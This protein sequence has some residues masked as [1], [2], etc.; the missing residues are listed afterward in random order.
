MTARG[1][2]RT[3]ARP[4]HGTKD[5]NATVWNGEQ[6]DLDAY[7]A[8]LGHEG[9]RSPTLE[10]LRAVHRAHVLTVRWDALDSFLYRA[11]A[12]DLP[13]LQ[14][15]LLRRGRGGYC[16]EHALLYGAALERLGFRFTGVAA[17]IRMGSDRIIAATHAMKVVELDGARWLSDIGFGAGPLGPIEL[18]DGNEVTIEGWPFLLR[19]GEFTPGTDGWALHHRDT[20]G[21]WVVRHTFTLTPQYPVDYE[22]GSHYV[23]SGP[24]SA[25]NRR[26]F[27]QRPR[28]DRVDQLDALTWTTLRPDDTG[29]PVK[30]VLDP[31]ELPALL[32]DTFGVELS[33]EEAELLVTRVRALDV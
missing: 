4:L 30:R 18:V 6:L 24:H 19:R 10:T 28:P 7:L 14:D 16:Y 5:G 29:P 20:D 27:V 1:R 22:M 32:A 15:K 9:D 12:L 23:A 21:S 3:V 11:V 33:D 31:G 2:V 13:S 25:F 26:P 17:R 8:H